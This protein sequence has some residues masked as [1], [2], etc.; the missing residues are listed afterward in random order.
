MSQVVTPRLTSWC[1]E[2]LSDSGSQDPALLEYHLWRLQVYRDTLLKT[3]L[4]APQGNGA[5]GTGNAVFPVFLFME[6]L[7]APDTV[8]LI[9]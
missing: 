2:P 5:P 4:G 7:S 6:A 1:P 9:S 8:H 3:R